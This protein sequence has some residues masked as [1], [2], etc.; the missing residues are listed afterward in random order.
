MS[1]LKDS[2]PPST[3]RWGLLAAGTI[4]TTF[5]E[6]LALVDGA[7]VTAVAARDGERA[8]AFAARHGIPRSYGGYE[9]LLADSDVDVVY[10]STLHPAHAQWT[11]A[12]LESGKHVLC[13]KPLTMNADE[14]VEVI[15]AARRSGRFLMEGFMYRFHPQ[16]PRLL[17]LIHQGTVGEVRSVQIAIC[18]GAEL[19]TLPRLIEAELGGGAILDV[20]SYCVSLARLI[21]GAALDSDAAPVPVDVHGMA[22][23]DDAGRVDLRSFGLMRFDGGTVAQM[24]AGVSTQPVHEVKVTGTE[25]ELTIVEPPWLPVHHPPNTTSQIVLSD[26]GR[27]RGVISVHSPKSLFAYEA[28]H[29]AAFANGHQSPVI[30]WAETLANMRTVDRWRES[31]RGRVLAGA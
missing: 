8:A 27:P 3:L 7:E 16:I 11:I 10:V 29:V 14:A 25:G 9:A 22:T 1:L 12:A 19:S 13:E 18:F 31:I 20:G 21:A 30:P 24:T 15:A 2:S 26:R 6:A 5:A 17:E 4:A 28:E 23:L